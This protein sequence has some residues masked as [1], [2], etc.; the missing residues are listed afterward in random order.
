MGADVPLLAQ[1]QLQRRRNTH[2]RSTIL[3]NLY[4]CLVLGEFPSNSAGVWT[5][6]VASR[7]RRQHR[8]FK[9]ERLLEGGLHS[10]FCRREGHKIYEG[11]ALSV[12]NHVH[13][14]ERVELAELRKEG[15]D[16]LDVCVVRESLDVDAEIGCLLCSLERHDGAV[17][18][19]PIVVEP[20]LYA[21]PR[22]LRLVDASVVGVH[23]QRPRHAVISVDLRV[24]IQ[25]LRLADDNLRGKQVLSTMKSRLGTLVWEGG[26]PSTFSSSSFLSGCTGLIMSVC[27][28]E[29]WASFVLTFFSP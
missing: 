29:N 6:H 14:G 1:G 25:R 2:R 13:F 18:P 17:A 19:F 16:V 21:F 27:S 11:F 9:Q 24:Q 5:P 3:I 26:S 4:L 28:G 10:P 8:V 23:E 22:A 20:V 15:L 12:R 7:L